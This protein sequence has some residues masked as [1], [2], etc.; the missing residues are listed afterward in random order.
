MADVKTELVAVTGLSSDLLNIVSGYGVYLE[1]KRCLKRGESTDVS[2]KRLDLWRGNRRDHR[3]VAE[4]FVH[5]GYADIDAWRTAKQVLYGLAQ[6]REEGVNASLRHCPVPG[7]IERSREWFV[8][9]I[10]HEIPD[11]DS[12]LWWLVDREFLEYRVLPLF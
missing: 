1:F 11:L 5:G 6:Q 8:D 2:Y 10:R 12:L 3:T 9:L 4:Q 7:F